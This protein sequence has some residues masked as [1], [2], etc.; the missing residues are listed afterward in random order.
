MQTLKGY[1]YNYSPTIDCLGDGTFTFE[2]FVAVMAN[3]GGISEHPEEDEEEELRQAFK[4]ERDNN[5][6]GNNGNPSERVGAPC[7][8]RILNRPLM[9]CLYFITKTISRFYFC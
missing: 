6:D 9:R 8:R 1:L 5:R 3:M 7:E 2:E 4:V